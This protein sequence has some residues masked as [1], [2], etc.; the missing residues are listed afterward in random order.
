M[1]KKKNKRN[2]ITTYIEN[3]TGLTITF[4][5]RKNEISITKLYNFCK[6]LSRNSD[7]EK[8]FLELGV[9]SNLIE[10]TFKK[11]DSNE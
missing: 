4:I 9:P 1:V 7:A 5:A 3:H 11:D 8:I 10:Q 6:G 2:L